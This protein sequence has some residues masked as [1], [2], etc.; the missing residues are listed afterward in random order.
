AE[1]PSGLPTLRADELRI[2]QVLTNL[3]GN[4]IKFSPA[5]SVV[6]LSV[7][8]SDTALQFAVS[9]QGKGIVPEDHARIFERFYQSDSNVRNRAGGYGL[10][11][12]IAKLI[13]EQHHGRI[14]VES[15]PGEGT[16]FYFTL[17]RSGSSEPFRGGPRSET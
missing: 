7:S 9:D 3:L 1:L 2:Q 10:G 16:T 8:E 5:E 15:E 4:A 14:W 12:S 13:V 17:P 6:R 11:L